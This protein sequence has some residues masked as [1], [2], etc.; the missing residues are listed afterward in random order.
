MELLPIYK[1]FRHARKYNKYKPLLNSH[2]ILVT[3]TATLPPIK[4][5]TRKYLPWL[6]LI[7]Q[8]MRGL[9]LSPDNNLYISNCWSHSILRVHK[10]SADTTLLADRKSFFWVSFYNYILGA[11]DLDFPRFFRFY[12]DRMIVTEEFN[13]AVKIFIVEGWFSFFAI[14]DCDLYF[15]ISNSA[16]P[17][18]K[19]HV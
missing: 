12:R 7:F 19:N 13:S 9:A 10:E 6:I 15:L 3:R 14:V 4:K 11:S 1:S 18:I 8:E 17:C 5:R 16:K 2:V